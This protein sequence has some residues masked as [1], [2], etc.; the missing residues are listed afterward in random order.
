M[1]LK[2]RQLGIQNWRF[3]VSLNRLPFLYLVKNTYFWMRLAVWVY[4]CKH[5]GGPLAS[6][7][8][9]VYWVT[10][11]LHCLVVVV[12]VPIKKLACWH[13]IPSL[14]NITRYVKQRKILDYLEHIT[15]RY[16][17][18]ALLWYPELVAQIRGEPIPV[19]DMTL[20]ESVSHWPISVPI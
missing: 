6:I 10:R 16:N 9:Q 19:G 4:H 12:D 13:W 18:R 2:T 15:N 11:M 20:N 7:S 8:A 3:Q 1:Y 14:S 17:G 5:P